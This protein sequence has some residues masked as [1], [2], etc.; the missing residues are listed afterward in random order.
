M[1]VLIPEVKRP[2]DDRAIYK[3]GE[4][5]DRLPGG[6][7]TGRGRGGP[8]CSFPR[9]GRVRRRSDSLP[10]PRIS[11]WRGARRPRR[12]VWAGT[13]RVARLSRCSRGRDSTVGPGQVA[14]APAAAGTAQGPGSPP[15]W[16]AWWRR[17]AGEG[18]AGA[19]SVLPPARLPGASRQREPEVGV[20]PG[21]LVRALIPAGAPLRGAASLDERTPWAATR[22]SAG[23]WETRGPGCG[24]ARILCRPRYFGGQWD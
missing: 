14:G 24:V 10:A 3:C 8:Q 16:V 17:A 15:S 19:P 13:V 22:P 9:E 11:R 5:P 21:D 20:G 12:A 23:P 18:G 4:P 6:G 2:Q 7:A 1:G